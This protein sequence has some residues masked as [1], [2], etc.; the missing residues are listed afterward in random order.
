MN[1]KA[2]PDDG[3]PIDPRTKQPIGPL[4]TP[5]Y[6]PGYSTL[7]QQKY[8]DAATRE[9]VLDRVHNVPPIRFFSQF[10]AKLLEAVCN[11]VLP[12]DD[13][14]EAHRIPIVPAIDEKLY[15]DTTDG[16]RFED[17]PEQR[18]AFRLGL[19]G[20]ERIAQECY[21]ASFLELRVRAQDAILKSLHDGK[22][23]A[24]HEIWDHMPAHRF[25][26]ELLQNCVE[27][28]YSHPFAWDEIGFGGPAYPRAYMR[29]E[30]GEP[31]PWEVQEVRYE[32]EPPE[33]A[34]SGGFEAVGGEW[35][36]LASPGRGGTH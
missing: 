34:A 11:C 8:W 27:A 18:Q 16:Y 12:Q 20:I 33:S 4:A 14:D 29:L 25:F 17:M 5:G 9:L 2:S 15:E 24:A 36:H 30:R 22:P 21:G 28:Y 13:R 6:Y 31:E 3:R 7:A 23:L 19:A 35:E 32:W 10:E 26:M 1:G